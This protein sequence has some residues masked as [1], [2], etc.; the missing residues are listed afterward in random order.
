MNSGRL[1]PIYRG[2]HGLDRLVEMSA[3]IT[4]G[5]NVLQLLSKINGHC[6][7]VVVP[8]F[9]V[10]SDPFRLGDLACYRDV[11]VFIVMASH[12]DFACH[13]WTA[14]CLST[15]FANGL[16]RQAS[17]GGEYRGAVIIIGNYQFCAFAD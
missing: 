14:M 15:G 17:N 7:P 16:A 5:I 6:A 8:N 2:S 4:S 3:A 9:S 12:A 11:C 10:D 13:L 1:E